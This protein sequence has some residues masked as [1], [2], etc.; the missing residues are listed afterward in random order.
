MS[1][2]PADDAQ[3]VGVPDPGATTQHPATVVLGAGK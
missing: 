2:A 1:T 3:S